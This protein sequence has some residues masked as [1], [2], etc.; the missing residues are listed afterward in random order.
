M[1]E[2]YWVKRILNIFLCLV[3]VL[4]CVSCSHGFMNCTHDC[5]NCSHDS[6][7][8]NSQSY[9]TQ[10]YFPEKWETQNLLEQHAEIVQF[11]HEDKC[12]TCIF[13]QTT[14]IDLLNTTFAVESEKGLII[15][16]S[17]TTNYAEN[18]ALKQTFSVMEED[19]C[20]S[21]YIEG[22]Y[23]NIE[24]WRDVFLLAEEQPESVKEHLIERIRALIEKIQKMEK[25]DEG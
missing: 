23:T 20:S 15:Y 18:L 21:I 22:E 10:T 5:E 2:N 14:I 4:F 8:R 24:L 1:R 6:P 13:L 16:H 9:K 7:N 19:I 17:V 3:L 25:K 12:D 11:H